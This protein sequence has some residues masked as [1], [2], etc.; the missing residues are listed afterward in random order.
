MQRFY[1]LLSVFELPFYIIHS[2]STNVSLICWNNPLTWDLRAAPKDGL[3]L[4]IIVHPTMLRDGPL[5]YCPACNGKQVSLNNVIKRRGDN[6]PPMN[7]EKRPICCF[8]TVVFGLLTQ[9]LLNDS[10]SMKTEIKI[11]ESLVWF[12]LWTHM[13]T[14]DW[15]HV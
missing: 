8:L 14:S 15:L 3:H 10:Q 6:Y 13:Q 1:Q 4:Y 11:D 2:G 9:M 12:W 7:N 5:V